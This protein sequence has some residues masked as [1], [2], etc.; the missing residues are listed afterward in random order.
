MTPVRG[1][2]ALV[3]LRGKRSVIAS[4][5]TATEQAWV[6]RNILQV[7]LPHLYLIQVP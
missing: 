6:D 5:D 4:A 2:G 3:A 1:Q 7:P